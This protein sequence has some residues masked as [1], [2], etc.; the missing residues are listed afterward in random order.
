MMAQQTNLDT[1]S[2][3][4]ANV[5]TTAYKQ[6]RAEFQDMMYQT[7]VAPGA[8]TGANS[9][10]PVGMQVGLGSMFSASA[11]NFDQGSLQ[12]TGNPL[13][14]GINGDGFFQ[15]QMPD[16]TTAYTRDGSF[17]TDAT[18]LMVT[19]EGYAI[20]PNITIP[21]GVTSL[22]I[23]PSGVVSASVP[24]QNEPQE[25]GQ[26][27]LAKFV[28]PS[29]LRRLGQNLY[30]SNSASGDP[31]VVTPGEE[32]AGQLQAGYLEGS[33]VQIVEEMVRMI[34]AQRAYEINSKA[35][36]T[37]DDMLQVLNSLKR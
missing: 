24:G 21:A 8:P 15:V 37:A 20:E 28:N 12:T 1:I 36:Q 27:T 30:E 35:I 19:S 13:D 10:Q 29:G 6:Q 26:I 22:S 3:N 17:K 23:S 5:N 18:G 16:G 11:T 2:N 33:N 34:L 14:I 9:R 7:L 31:Q 32:G 25:L 4:L